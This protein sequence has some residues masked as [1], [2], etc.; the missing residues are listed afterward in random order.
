MEEQSLINPG[1]THRSKVKLEAIYMNDV[2]PTFDDIIIAINDRATDIIGA[3]MI[4]VLVEIQRVA[5]RQIKSVATEAPVNENE[6]ASN[7]LEARELMRELLAPEGYAE[8]SKVIRDMIEGAMKH[9]NHPTVLGAALEVG[10]WMRGQ[11][12]VEF[13]PMLLATAADMIDEQ[14]HE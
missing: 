14:A 7:M 8:Q 10:L 2:P 13:V 6:I 4:D 9:D 3:K 11:G 5:K 12:V 1:R